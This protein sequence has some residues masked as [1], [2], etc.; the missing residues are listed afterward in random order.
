MYITEQEIMSQ[1]IALEKTFDYVMLQREEIE[2]FFIQYPFKKFIFLGCGS[3]YMLCKSG[4]TLFSACKNTSASAIAGGDYLIH[5][6]FYE[7]T[8][9]EAIVV[10]L[11]R[12]GQTSEIIRSAK[13]IKE[14]YGNPIISICLK[15]DNHMMQYSDLN[16][17]MDWCFDQSVC[18]TR[19][20]TNL[21]TAMLL[22]AAVYKG[23][24]DAIASVK[25]AISMNE[26]FKKEYQPILKSL[27]EKDWDNVIVLADGPVG[28]LA[29]EGALAFTE[30]AMLPGKCFHLLD[31]RHGP[32]VIN[33]NKTLTVV[34]LSPV[35]TKLQGDLVKDLKKQGGIVITV[36]TQKDNLYDADRHIF[37]GEIED[38]GA[39]GIPFI[40]V[41]Q[42]AA[43]EKSMMLGNNPDAPAGLDPFITLT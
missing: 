11:S 40:F 35:E 18:Q 14:K 16:L 23:D 12:S 31:Y 33:D 1:H 43:Y 29:E 2:A 15:E 38:F 6:G 42:M 5:H 19:S 20:V 34:L 26:T 4:E 37:I 9:K 30:I 41:L 25:K 24:E 32:I 27:A 22:L 28:G 3:S 8:V 17:T 7:E 21:Y 13:L 39:M 36:S 10:T